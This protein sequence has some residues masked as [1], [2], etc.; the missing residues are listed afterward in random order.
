MESFNKF[1][2]RFQNSK[3]NSI[4]KEKENIEKFGIKC[5]IK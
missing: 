5:K 4:E 3:E 2:K 1:D